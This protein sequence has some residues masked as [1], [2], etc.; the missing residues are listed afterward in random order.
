[1]QLSSY[2]K[3]LNSEHRYARELV[4]HPVYVEEK[5]D[6]SQFSFG[7]QQN[8]DREDPDGYFENAW[9]LF[10]R[11]KR[12]YID[13]DNPPKLFSNAVKAVKELRT[14][15][16][17]GWTYRAECIDSKKHNALTY[18]RVPRHSF[19]LF[20]IDK[21]MEDYATRL[22][23][24]DE[25][26][27]MEVEAVQWLVPGVTYAGPGQFDELLKDGAVTSML[28]GP[29]EGIV[30]KPRDL[31]VGADGKRLV[32]KV[33]RDEFKEI[34]RKEWKPA[35]G[36]SLFGIL[37]EYRSEARWQKALQRLNEEDLCK[38]GPE[39]IGALVRYVQEDVVEECRDEIMDL[40]WTRIVKKDLGRAAVRGLPEWYKARLLEEA[41]GV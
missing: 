37:E 17:M 10:C 40:I 34:H 3:I 15:L 29:I 19:V 13:M 25:A 38:G 5:L 26:L 20:D 28:G 22:E 24:I 11:S 4:G 33:V 12:A 16:R 41:S 27:R 9:E 1:M 30:I 21:G 8:K 39:D 6:G 2:S 32:A 14:V 36:N 7:F 31:V 18:E 35:G 23:L